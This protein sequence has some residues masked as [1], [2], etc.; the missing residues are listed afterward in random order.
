MISLLR[1]Q[2][3]STHVSLKLCHCL[4]LGIQAGLLMAKCHVTLNFV[5]ND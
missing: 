4:T 3:L 1:R 5:N 2:S